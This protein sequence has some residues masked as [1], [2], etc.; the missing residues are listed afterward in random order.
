MLYVTYV[1]PIHL[2]KTHERK[3]LNI[4]FSGHSGLN[5]GQ[6]VDTGDT[7]MKASSRYGYC[8]KDGDTDQQDENSRFREHLNLGL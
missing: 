3:T 4:L 2:K 5:S 6:A 8:L 7:L 1:R